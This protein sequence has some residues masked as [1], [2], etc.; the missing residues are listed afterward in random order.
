MN[1]GPYEAA[2]GGATITAGKPRAI[3]VIGAGTM[4][5]GIAELALTRGYRVALY[6]LNAEQ[7]AR[8]QHAIARSLEKLQARGKLQ[9][10]PDT[11]LAHLLGTTDLA[12]LGG[13]DVVIEAAPERLDLKQKLFAELETLCPQAILA[14]NTSTLLV[15]AIA[16]S[17]GD[18]ARVVGM[19]FFNPAQI[20]PLVEVVR[21]QDTSARTVEAIMELARDL[22]KTPVLCD[23]TPGFIVNRVARPFYGE[24]LRLAAEG[25]ASYAE[26]D[27]VMRGAGFRM[28]PFELMDLIGLDINFASTVSVY[29]AFFHDPRYRPHPL[30]ARM[31]AGGRLGRKTGQGFYDHSASQ[32]APQSEPSSSSIPQRPQVR[33]HL[34]GGG[35]LR[36]ALEELLSGYE[37]A[38]ASEADWVIDCSET[39]SSV[40]AIVGLTPRS[41][42]LSLAYA[43]SATALAARYPFPERVVGFSCLSPLGDKSVIEIMPALQSE[44][45][46]AQ[47]TETLFAAAGLSVQMVGETP[48]GIA[49]RTVAMLANEAF[50]ALA[51]GV[52]D[53]TTID[54]AMKLGTN[55]PRGPL[56]WAQLIGLRAVL[57]ILEA[58][59]R[60]TGDDRY[61]PHPLLRRM[62]LAGKD[63]F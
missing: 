7:L 8:A 42:V 33:L 22:G 50:S 20:L 6:D 32:A 10:S 15:S 37:R 57:S 4:G 43:G 52:A 51:E 17:V 29:E 46:L 11:L 30:Q 56:E 35:R 55:Y 13:A 47:D 18:R 2:L 1:A 49:A 63:T 19:H 61:R 48:G 45:G 34:S 9:D 21:G 27:A 16:S 54:T 31:V 14:T 59:Q 12:G 38:L 60:E 41:R 26:I 53:Q 23:D 40:A 28:G 5:A 44:P 39:V 3:G 36:E 58:L 62:V 25:V 24:G